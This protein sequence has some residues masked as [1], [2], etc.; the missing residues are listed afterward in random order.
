MLTI[1]VWVNGGLRWHWGL[2]TATAIVLSVPQGDVSSL[3]GFCLA[4][5]VI[6]AV[7]HTFYCHDIA[8]DEAS[9]SPL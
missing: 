7:S 9:E 6:R 2:R 4:K 8:I 3:F 1:G 5:S